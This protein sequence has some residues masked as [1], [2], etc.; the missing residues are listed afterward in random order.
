MKARREEERVEENDP[1]APGHSPDAE[2][3]G[4]LSGD[5]G[6]FDHLE[7]LRWR[8]IKGVGALV[9]TSTL[10]A[11][12]YREL[13][14]ILLKP[15]TDLNLSLQNLAPFGQITITI[16]VCLL[17][18]FILGIPLILYQFWAFIRPGLY[19]NE[20]KYVG[21][22]SVATMFAFLAGVVFAFYLMVPAAL[23]FSA[24]FTAS[25]QLVNQFTIEAYFGF[26]LGFILSSGA[27]FEMPVLSWALSRIGIITPTLLTTYRRHA[28]V[29]LL[30]IAAIVTP[31]PDP[32]NQVMMAGP[33]YILYEISI[34]VSRVAMRQRKESLAE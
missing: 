10:C 3:E 1:G 25:D 30:I 9:L 4:R 19:K 28:V 12:F 33:L 8:L 2:R 14:V 34:I 29:I 5:M 27:V 23:E 26:I 15:A 21:F 32:V 13:W 22:L 20:Q 6:F 16:Q 24:S 31:T 18:G 11:I 17:S 7:E